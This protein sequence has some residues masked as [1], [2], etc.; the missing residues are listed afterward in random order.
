MA[1]S[2]LKVL[3]YALE[4]AIVYPLY[5]LA[6]LLPVQAA[7]AIGALIGDCFYHLHSGTRR[8]RYNLQLV[9]PEHVAE[10][11]T[12]IRGVWRN[13]GRVLLEYP[14]L[15]HIWKSGRVTVTGSRG[16]DI[17]TS[18]PYLFVGIHQANWEMG[19]L[20]AARQGWELASIYRPLNN[21]FVDP[22]LRF[23]RRA[24]GQK[25]Y[26]KSAEGG[27][28]L[29]RHMRKGGSAAMLIDQRLGDGIT[30]PFFGQPALTPPMAAMVAVKYGVAI[31]PVQIIR[32]PGVRFDVI[33]HDE[34]V[35]PT[36]GTEAEKI[37]ALTTDLYKM[38]ESWIRQHPEQW[39]WM[40]D[41]WRGKKPAI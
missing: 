4:A 1:K 13:M 34:P 12:I 23:V 32:K 41:R 36:E 24:N 15:D 2:P 38:F 29:L 39:L 20:V 7:S 21:P 27:M 33:V 18:K 31:V 3:R 22:L 6:R 17:D 8:A 9:M 19:P 14:H 35:M 37:T 25:L 10:H 26:T 30:V 11:E 16:M 28:A 40:H 5:G